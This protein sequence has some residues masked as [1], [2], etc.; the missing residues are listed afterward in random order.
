M[1]PDEPA[2]AKN[3]NPHAIPHIVPV[4]D[5]RRPWRHATCGEAG[6]APK[7]SAITGWWRSVSTAVRAARRWASNPAMS[8]LMKTFMAGSQSRCSI[9]FKRPAGL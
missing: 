9:P 8:E 3:Q 4:S 5:V 1:A 7:S 6:W 2:S